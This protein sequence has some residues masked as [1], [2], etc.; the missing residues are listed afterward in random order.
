[1]SA[2]GK[3]KELVH[4]TLARIPFALLCFSLASG[5]GH[6]L[7]TLVESEILHLKSDLVFL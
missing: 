3:G 1:M 4:P 6:Q 7:T 5:D 2:L